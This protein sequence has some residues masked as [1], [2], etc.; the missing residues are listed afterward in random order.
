MKRPSLGVIVAA[1]ALMT[2]AT[3]AA[4]TSPAHAEQPHT[5]SLTPIEILSTGTFPSVYVLGTTGCTQPSCLHLISTRIN[6]LGDTPVTLS[7]LHHFRDGLGDT[8]LRSLG[9]AD[10]GRGYALVGTTS[11]TSLYVTRNG[12]ATWHKVPAMSGLTFQ[13][14]TVTGEVLYATLAKCTSFDD[15]CV[16]VTIAKSQLWPI[17]WTALRLPSIPNN[18]LNAGLPEVSAVGTTVWLSEIENNAEFIW[19]STNEGATFHETIEP[20]LVSINGCALELV[21]PADAWA[22]CPTGMLVVFYYSSDGGAHWVNVPQRPYAGTSG[23]FFAPTW[24]SVAYVDYGESTNNFYRVNMR[25]DVAVHVGELGC[26]ITQTPVFVTD[27]GLVVCTAEHGSTQSTA[28]YSTS[29]GGALWH[30]VGLET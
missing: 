13:R 27:Q 29:D 22:Q 15:N 16:D 9:F 3:S 1:F 8:T 28:L 2:A 11:T 4:G 6:G 17:H 30:K 26:Q 25:D 12:A 20:E 5:T 7:P 10:G 14:I 23:G 19:R 18:G 21:T 24:N